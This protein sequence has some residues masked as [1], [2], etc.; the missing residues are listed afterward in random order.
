MATQSEIR[1]VLNA[2]PGVRRVHDL[3]VWPLS[4]TVAALTAHLEHDGTRVT[5]ELLAEAQRAIATRFG[6][7]HST[8]Q[9]ENVGCG[10]DCAEH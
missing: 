8:L 4:T 6:I 10:S 9:F 2:V 1:A 5:D 7:H 3:H